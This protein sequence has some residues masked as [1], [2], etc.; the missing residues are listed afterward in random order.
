MTQHTTVAAG[1]VDDF[2]SLI[3]VMSTHPHTRTHAQVYMVPKYG[4]KPSKKARNSYNCK[5]GNELYHQQQSL[6]GAAAG[7][8]TGMWKI[9]LHFG[10]HHH[11]VHVSRTPYLFQRQYC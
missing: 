11:V 7:G 2:T 4:C 9:H 3:V 5:E 8:T 10:I 6:T 1:V